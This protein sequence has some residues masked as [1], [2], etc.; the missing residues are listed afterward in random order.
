MLQFYFLSVFLNIMAGFILFFEDD[1]CP[2]EF[3]GDFTMKGG[4]VKLIVGILVAFTGLVK[5]FSPLQGNVPVIGDLIPAV[6]GLLCGFTLLFEYYRHRSSIDQSEQ[7]K[8]IEVMILVNRKL[9]GGAAFITAAL[10][11]LFP[12]MPLL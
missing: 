7:T 12:R 1:N 3:K 10:H 4:A 5:L 2:I 8:K 11:F 6:V 9:I